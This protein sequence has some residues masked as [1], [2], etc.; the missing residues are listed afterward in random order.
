MRVTKYFI[1]NSCVFV[2]FFL[3]LIY[4][5]DMRNEELAIKR[6]IFKAKL[7]ELEI[8][9]TSYTADNDEVLDFLFEDAMEKFD[10]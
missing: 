7:K 1:V 8:L 9:C 6:V 4:V 5:N 3:I 2:V 10:E